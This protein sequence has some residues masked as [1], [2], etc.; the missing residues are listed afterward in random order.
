MSPVMDE[1]AAPGL[2]RLRLA[3]EAQ[4]DE[5][6]RLKK[7]HESLTAEVEALGLQLLTTSLKAESCAA[8]RAE[9][10]AAGLLDGGGADNNSSSHQDRQRSQRSG[11][12]M[13]S[14]RSATPD[15][16]RDPNTP[17]PQLGDSLPAPLSRRLSTVTPLTSTRLGRRTSRAT[18]SCVAPS[19][20]VLAPS[21]RQVAPACPWR[22]AEERRAAIAPISVEGPSFGSCSLRVVADIWDVAA[23]LL[24]AAGLSSAL[25]FTACAVRFGQF[26][27]AFPRWFPRRIY[28]LG[29]SSV[30]IGAGVGSALQTVERLDPR[31]G[32]WEALPP[33]AYARRHAAAA[34]SG[35]AIHVVGGLGRDGRA[36]ATAECYAPG[37]SAW[38][39]TPAMAAPRFG[40]AAANLGGAIYVA[41]GHDGQKTLVTV[42]R[43]LPAACSWEPAPPLNVPRML[44]FAASRDRSLFVIGG[45]DCGEKVHVSAER[46]DLSHRRWTLEAL[47]PQRTP[48]LTAA[49]ANSEESGFLSAGGYAE[50]DR[51]FQAVA[52]VEVLG[53]SAESALPHAWSPLS[54]LK[55]PRI[56]AA[57]ALADGGDVYVLGGCCNGE[58]L[59]SVERWNAQVERW[60]PAPPLSVARDAAVVVAARF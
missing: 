7:Q 52:A 48:R 34:V 36:L 27:F 49:I 38:S 39:A 25:N 44:A 15:W 47:M 53:I 60:E 2:G 42:E 6:R 23:L 10:A 5:I 3:I 22:P 31:S 57:A 41:G 13:P 1:G 26:A 32:A 9:R 28:V 19:R 16:H 35:G 37:A 12:P 24:R 59:A 20:A 14:V 8:S 46:L 50:C 55:T 30:R 21:R 11:S 33:M 4:G 29:G 58:A 45:T 40:A 56:R 51:T 43:L 18:A 54:P 17:G